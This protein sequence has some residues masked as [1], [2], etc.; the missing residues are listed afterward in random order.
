M[1]SGV[2]AIISGALS[3]T[4]TSPHSAKGSRT[5][6]KVIST[7][8]NSASAAVLTGGFAGFSD[9]A[10]LEPSIRCDSSAQMPKFRPAMAVATSPM[11]YSRAG[12][13]RPSEPG[14]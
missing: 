10:R 14:K 6:P 5:V 9:S 7:R 3:S 11:P 13:A 1:F 2:L 8:S 4:T 12:S